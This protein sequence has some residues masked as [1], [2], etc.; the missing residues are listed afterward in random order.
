MP[1]AFF[2]RAEPMPSPDQNAIARVYERMGRFA[3]LVYTSLPTIVFIVANLALGLTSAVV[4]ALAVAI[5]IFL[6]RLHK[7]DS[8]RGALLGLIGVGICVGTAYLTGSARA[9]FLYGIYGSLLYCTLFTLSILVRFPLVGII[10]S[11]VA[12]GGI[13]WRRTRPILHRYDTAT[14]AWALIYGARFAVQ[15]HLYS[16]G[17]DLRLALARLAMGWPLGALGML[18]TVLTI[19]HIERLPHLPGPAHLPE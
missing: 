9:Y 13:G 18:I 5:G 19:R 3:G 17:S 1:T 12:G 11:A 4:I 2:R 10:W 15:F 14:A 16:T 8:R 6:W 7:R